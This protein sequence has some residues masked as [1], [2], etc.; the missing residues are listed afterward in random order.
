MAT[1]TNILRELSSS[2]ANRRLLAWIMK[3]G[4]SIVYPEDNVSRICCVLG[5]HLAI[6]LATNF[7][8]PEIM[9]FSSFGESVI[10]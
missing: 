5:E 6:N 10:N 1:K 8:P 3:P 9:E 2:D 7:Q 4:A